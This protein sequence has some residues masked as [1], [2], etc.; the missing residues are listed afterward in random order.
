MKF[1]K[2][3]R[4][5]LKSNCLLV[6]VQTNHVNLRYFFITKSLNARQV[7]WTEKLMIFNFN[8]EYKFDWLNSVNA[9]SKKRDYKS[10]D[11][12]KISI[13]LFL[14]L[15]HKLEKSLWEAHLSENLNF[16]QNYQA[17]ETKI[18]KFLISRLLIMKIVSEKIA[19]DETV[20]SFK[21]L[22]WKLQKKNVFSQRIFEKVKNLN[23]CKSR[24]VSNTR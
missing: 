24:S 3:W 10:F 23:N 12:K 18:L 15:Q 5:Y 4:H 8:I 22:I 20:F 19:C 1:F 21:D 16:L 6:W 11:D 7:R 2:K 14:F 17:S 9:L 13:E